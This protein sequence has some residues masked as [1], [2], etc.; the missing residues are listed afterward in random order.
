[1]PESDVI[2]KYRLNAMPALTLG[3]AAALEDSVR[4]IEKIAVL[5]GALDLA[6]PALTGIPAT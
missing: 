1:M 4:A 5:T 2:E 3:A 6:A